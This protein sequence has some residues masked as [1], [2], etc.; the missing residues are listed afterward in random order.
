M[1]STFPKRGTFLRL[2][3][4]LSSPNAIFLPWNYPHLLHGYIYAAVT[5]ERPEIGVF[6]HERGFESEKHRYKLFVFS[7]LFATKSRSTSGS[8]LFSPPL[9]WWIGSPLSMFLEA[10]T[11][12]FLKEGKVR[13]EESV[14]AVEEVEVESPP[15]FTR[16]VFCETISSLSFRPVCSEERSSIKFSSRRKTL[17]SS[18]LW[19]SGALNSSPSRERTSGDTKGSSLPRETRT[20]CSSPMTPDW[21]NEIVRVLGCFG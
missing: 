18:N 7:K 3:I 6:L 15:D 2:R 13:L 8:L 14:L 20:S 17:V 11:A 12:S 10:L 4:T 19:E 16:R 5:R 9:R 1:G 21:G